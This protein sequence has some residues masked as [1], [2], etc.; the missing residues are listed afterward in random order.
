MKLKRD[1]ESYDVKSLRGM[2]EGVVKMKKHCET[3]CSLGKLLENKIQ[4]AKANG[5]Q[6]VNTDRAEALINEYLKKM[7]D[8]EKEYSELS[9]SV[10]ELIRK[11]EDIWSP[12]G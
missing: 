6:D 8:A 12:W 9:V 3:L 4:V 11:I 2:D 1:I 5:F 10:K 7:A